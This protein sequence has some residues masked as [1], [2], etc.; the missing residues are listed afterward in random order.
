MRG[1]GI[2]IVILASLCFSTAQAAPVVL[3]NTFGPGDTYQNG[4]SGIGTV[5][6]GEDHDLGDQF[7]FSGTE[8]YRL[9]TVEVGATLWSGNNVL[10]VWLMRDIAG[11]PGAIIESFTLTGAMGP[12]GLINP[13]VVATSVLL[14]V[15]TP[16]TPYWVVLS[17]PTG[18]HAI[19]NGGIN[20]ALILPRAGRTN[21]GPWWGGSGPGGGSGS[22][23]AF[24]VNGTPITTPTV[25]PAPA[26]ILLSTVGAG[27]VTWL[28]RR[29]TL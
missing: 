17:A 8:S 10:D 3:F 12:F 6:I 26:A 28:R 24:R 4:G 5:G 7:R 9:A 11:Q 25:I 23:E 29:R 18:T 20:P 16:D 1:Y 27:F 2:T 13:P 19:W 15:L 22:A 14:P 21:D